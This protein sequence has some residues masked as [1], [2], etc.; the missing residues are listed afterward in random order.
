MLM[1]EK[2]KPALSRMIAFLTVEP[3]AKLREWRENN[4]QSGSKVLSRFIPVRIVTIFL[5]IGTQMRFGGVVRV[6]QTS[7]MPFLEI[8]Q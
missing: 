2:P 7:L 5:L 4:I 8:N 6:G 3:R 1:L